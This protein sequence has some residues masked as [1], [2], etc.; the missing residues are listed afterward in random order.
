MRKYIASLLACI[1]LVLFGCD[2]GTINT[3]KVNYVQK[4]GAISGFNL[5]TPADNGIVESIPTFKWDVANNAEHYTLEIASSTNFSQT[6]DAVYIKKSGI[7]TN[8]FNI[9]ANLK[10][11]D[12][13]YYWRV[14]AINADNSKLCNGDYSSFYYKAKSDQEIN[15]D[16][17]YADEWTVHKEGS[18]ADVSIDNN[19]F[20]KNNKKSLVIKFDQEKTNKG[21]P[22]SDGW[23]VIT[24][25]QEVEMYGVNAFF[26]NFYY[27]GQNA[28]VFLRAVDEDNEYYNAEIKVANNVKQT[29]IMKFDEFTLRT[30]GGTTIAN[31]VF[32]YNYI[33]YVEIV[34]EETFGDGICMI[35]DLKAVNYDN[36]RYMFFNKLDFN[37]VD[38]DS[39]ILDNYNFDTEYSSDGNSMKMS[40][41]GAA[42]EHNTSGI[43]GYGFV[44]VPVNKFMESGDALKLKIQYTGPSSANILLR[45]IEEDK[46]RWVY[47]QACNTIPE[48]GYVIIPYNAFTLS[49]YNGDGSRQ[50]YFLKQFQFGVEGVY[51]NGNATFSDIEIVNLKDRI[52]NLHLSS[53][54]SDGT[55]DNFDNYTTTSQIYYKWQLSTSNKDE[56]MALNKDMAY[57]ANNKCVKLTY[58]ADMAPAC[59][60]LQF[61]NSVE[62]YNA[63]SFWANDYS[64]KFDNAAF[65]YLSS[66]SAK[67]IITLYVESG[68]EYV[69]IIDALNRYWTNYTISFDDF[70][71]NSPK[72]V[73]T[74]ALESQNIVG[75]MFEFQY[76]YYT[77]DGTPYPV[78]MNNNAIYFDNLR[79]DNTDK[80]NSKELA[81]RI[82][83]E[84]DNPTLCY[85]DRFD[86]Y[87]ETSLLN[88]WSMNESLDYSKIELISEDYNKYMKMQYK[89]NSDSVS[90]GFTTL[91]ADEVQAKAIR[92]NLKGDG[93]A[94]VYINIYMTY[95]GE[96]YKYRATLSKVADSWNE[97][98]IGIGEKNFVKVEGTGQVVLSSRYVPNITKITFG[99]VNSTDKELSY[100][101][102]DEIRFDASDAVKYSTNTV[103]PIGG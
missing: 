14:L 23:M 86:D 101:Y 28:R 89:G 4:S 38:K 57:G 88:S 64:T 96:N 78:Y 13:T 26:F 85:I 68:E 98:T 92:L 12:T 95:A 67:M 19:N 87:T 33:K 100:V 8:E 62:G 74:M 54:E 52:E 63:L 75:L 1:S 94:T 6:E 27:S 3:N 5:Q 69:Y 29:I 34:F 36:Y 70:I 97:Y 59:Y 48:D 39:V 44:K 51:S 46:D 61:D 9:G 31:Q 10:Y 93:K 82:T 73:D 60:G 56:A 55:I 90:Y 49:E 47:R 17:E 76:Y 42:N 53:I 45:M 79:F 21:T 102:V 20:F 15:F 66:V 22:S 2:N 91:F 41:S 35:S 84:A 77:E 103:T 80:T 24:H 40:F 11:K 7:T 58:K 18:Q 99:I 32:D 43:N 72:T 30:K 50:F 83:P 65:N 25:Q 71:L 37:E 81:T 16:I